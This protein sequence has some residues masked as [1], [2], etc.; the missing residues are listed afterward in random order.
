MTLNEITALMLTLAIVMA[1][2]YYSF[3]PK[4]D[5]SGLDRDEAQRWLMR[6]M[7]FGGVVTTLVCVI[8]INLP[9]LYD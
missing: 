3:R 5:F 8:I 2:A 1:Y 4:K 9:R 7:S 6:I